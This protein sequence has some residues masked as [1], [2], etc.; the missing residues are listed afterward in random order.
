MTAKASNTKKVAYGVFIFL[1]LLYLSVSLFS[2]QESVLIQ[3]H[4][5][6]SHLDEEKNNGSFN[7]EWLDKVDREDFSVTSDLGYT[8]KGSWLKVPENKYN[9]T[10]VM[11]HGV[12][13]DRWRM[14]RYAQIYLKNGIDVVL[15]DHRKHGLSGGNE[16]SFGFFESQDLDKI[17]HWTRKQRPQHLIGAHGESLGAATVCM[18]SG[19]NEESHSV[20]FY[21]SDCAFSDTKELLVLRAKEDFGMPNIGFVGTTSLV[22]KLRAGFYFGDASPRTRV[23]QSKVPFLFIHGKS[24]TYI[25][26]E[27]SEEM[28]QMKSQGSKFI[29][30]V[31]NAEHAKSITVAPT[32]YEN[33]VMEFINTVISQINN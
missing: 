27:M 4:Q 33:K 21:I 10:M 19:K 29:W 23:A 13:H 9:L 1:F 12:T 30:L 7:T 3:T 16:V 28:Y 15:Y 18:H 32:K 20:N 5:G 2:Y 8:L 14:M 11:V 24:D 17:V 26:K 31:E 22:A 6:V 25:P